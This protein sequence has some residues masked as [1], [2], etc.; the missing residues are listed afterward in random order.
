MPPTRW[1]QIPGTGRG[2][3]AKYRCT[4]CHGTDVSTE[5]R[6]EDDDDPCCDICGCDCPIFDDCGCFKETM[7]D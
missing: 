5:C 3:D 4:H 6:K 7:G 2:E 1:E